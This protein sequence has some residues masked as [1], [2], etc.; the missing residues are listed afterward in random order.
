MKKLVKKHRGKYYTNFRNP[1]TGKLVNKSTGETDISKARTFAAKYLLELQGQTIDEYAFTQIKFKEI[2]Q[3]HLKSISPY[4]NTTKQR[5]ELVGKYFDDM[6]ISTIDENCIYRNLIDRYETEEEA[7]PYFAHLRA[8]LK[9]A[10][11]RK[12]I[13]EVPYVECRQSKKRRL[14]L[15]TNPELTA[16][17]NELP[18]YLI[19]PFL[20]LIATGYRPSEVA[21][22]KWDQVIMNGTRIHF[23][24][25]QKNN[26]YKTYPILPQATEII[27]RNKG[28]HPYFVFTSPYTKH[29]GLGQ[30]LTQSRGAFNKAKFRAGLNHIVTKDIRTTFLTK[31]DE[32]GLTEH[33]VAQLS[34]HEDLKSLRHYQAD[35]PKPVMEKGTLAAEQLLSGVA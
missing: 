20:F 22:L 7:Y 10:K 32:L 1:H 15:I 28:K 23:Y 14:I 17:K 19:D 26:E 33:Q 35:T 12:Y 13:K 25:N 11:K 18:D 30:V 34:R 24:G 3:L 5:S 27:D 4:S 8:V 21:A 31:L 29:R 9:T 6:K 2:R 16:W